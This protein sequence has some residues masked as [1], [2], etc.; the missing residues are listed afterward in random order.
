MNTEFAMLTTNKTE[1]LSRTNL[2][3]QTKVFIQGYI[4]H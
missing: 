4:L 1:H 2:F 3:I